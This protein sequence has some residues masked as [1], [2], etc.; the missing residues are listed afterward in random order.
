MKNFALFRFPNQTDT[1]LISANT[2]VEL[3][4]INLKKES[5]FILRPFDLEQ[6]AYLISDET[7]ILNPDNRELD[8]LEF[9]FKATLDEKSTTVNDYIQYVQQAIDG[10]K[11]ETIRKVVPA[12]IKV[13]TKIINPLQSFKKACDNYPNAF[14]SLTSTDKTGTWIG[15]TPEILLTI[16]KNKILKTAALAGTQESNGKSTSEAVWTQKEIEE[17]ALVSRYIINCFKELRLRE[18]EENGPK[19]IKAGNLLHLKTEYKINSKELDYDNLSSTLLDLLHP[20]SAVCGMPKQASIDLIKRRENFDR[21]LYSGFIGPVN[22]LKE[23]SLFVNLRCAQIKKKSVILYAGA[24]V[25]EDSNPEKEWM[26]TEKK[27]AIIGNIL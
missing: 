22:Y 25:T 7:T 10:I 9:H 3:R 11:S 19:T 27:C 23:S 4:N 2:L 24:G 18:F 15:A 21:E 8:E 5:G 26:E 1:H 17:Q 20:T 6:S 14:I 12:R 13:E 16:N